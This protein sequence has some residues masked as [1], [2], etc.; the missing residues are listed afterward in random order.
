MKTKTKVTVRSRIAKKSAGA[1]PAAASHE[2][3]V[4][5]DKFELR[6]NGEVISRFPNGSEGSSAAEA[7]EHVL[8]ASRKAHP[9]LKVRNFNAQGAEIL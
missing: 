4:H 6:E 9:G 5:P 3:H 2:I 1:K 8:A 7:R